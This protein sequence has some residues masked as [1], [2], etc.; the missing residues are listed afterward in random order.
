MK[1][2]RI[3]ALML[4]IAMMA[5]FAVAES[6]DDPVVVKAGD[7][8]IRLSEAQAFFDSFYQQ[9]AQLYAENGMTFSQTELSDLLTNIISILE[10]K[11][12]LDGKV[13]EYGLGEITE[14]DKTALRAE[15]E[16]AFE[17][18][19][20][21]YALSTGTSV[22]EA[23]A[24]IASQGITVDMI[25][26]QDL[27][28]L[29][30]TRL[31][32]Q[33]IKDVAV[34][35][36]DVQTEYDSYVE[37]DKETYENDIATYEMYSN[38]YGSSQIF[39]TPEGF[40]YIKHIL[41]AMPVDVGTQLN[42]NTEAMTE[43]QNEI[44]KLTEE[45]YALE[46]VTEEKAETAEART[47]EEIQADLDVQLAEQQK[48][49]TEYEDL[50]AEILPSLK[51]ILDEIY[52]KLDAG[53]SFDDLIAEYNT[54]TGVAS[55]PDGYKVHKDSVMWVTNFRDAAMALE[56]IG[57]ISEPVLSDFGVHILQYTGDVPGG[58]VA[59]S[60]EVAEDLRA[61]LLSYKQEEMYQ[62]TV[63]GW[64]KEVAIE[65]HPE[66]IKLP[67]VPEAAPEAEGEAAAPAGEGEAENTDGSVG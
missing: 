62:T 46:N 21:T 59:L 35:D 67:E 42:S 27:E 61:S 33:I 3:L 1:T 11:A 58:P 51:P 7:S 55:Q 18:D 37:Q 50:R 20:A 43:V 52:A 30:Y 54:D 23:R 10:Q 32:E 60:A 57:D 34:T 49:T 44:D 22:E 16:A 13:A 64:M 8:V 47:A 26:E 12:L 48:L 66:L 40:R 41:L 6:T 5:T 9:Y 25:Y 63:D 19:L 39:Y 14:A 53:T 36:A 15:I 29:P 56:K 4:A 65:S 28:L 45:L 2:F 31:N 17:Q 24:S 38:Y